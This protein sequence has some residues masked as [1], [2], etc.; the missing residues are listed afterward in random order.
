MP[1]RKATECDASSLKLS[2]SWT[3]HKSLVL[4]EGARLLYILAVANTLLVWT[5]FTFGRHAGSLALRALFALA[6]AALPFVTALIWARLLTRTF[7]DRPTKEPSSSFRVNLEIAWSLTL[8]VAAL[9]QMG[10]VLE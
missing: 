9:L 10:S 4:R 3:E 1:V 5:D 2:V 6:Y 8:V 7:P